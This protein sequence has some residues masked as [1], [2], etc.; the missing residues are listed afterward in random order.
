LNVF[1]KTDEAQCAA[2]ISLPDRVW[3]R[4]LVTIAL[5]GER[6]RQQ[7]LSKMKVQVDVKSLGGGYDIKEGVLGVDIVGFEDRNTGGRVGF[8]GLEGVKGDK[9]YE[10]MSSDG[11]VVVIKKQHSTVVPLSVE[12]G[13]GINVN[14]T[15]EVYFHI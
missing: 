14:W 9:D 8:K 15:S 1:I 12:S 3:V 10:D 2:L 13:G 5:I 11:S 7:S 4:L 6:G